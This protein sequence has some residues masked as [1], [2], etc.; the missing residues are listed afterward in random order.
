LKQTVWWTKSAVRPALFENWELFIKRYFDQKFPIKF[1]LASSSVAFLSKR[2]QES[3]VGRI[4]EFNATPFSAIISV[5]QVQIHAAQSTH[6]S[7]PQ[8]IPVIVS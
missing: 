2:V 4:I 6:S 7:Y 3:L 1:I 8:D 5:W